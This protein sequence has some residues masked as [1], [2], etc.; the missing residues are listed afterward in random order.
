MRALSLATALVVFLGGCSSAF[1]GYSIRQ[2]RGAETRRI[3]E[4][5]DPL[6]VALDLPSLK[7]IT[8]ASPCRIGFAVVR[9]P[10]VNVWSSPASEA[11]CLYF[12]LLVT[13]GAL[14]APT[15]ELMAM[16]AHELGHLT[17]RHT[18]QSTKQ[19]ALSED[20]WRTIQRQELEADRFAVA[21]LKR[22]TA[23]SSVASCEAMGRFLRRGVVDWY[24]AAISARLETAVTE[25]VESAEAACA[26]TEV[27]LAPPEAMEGPF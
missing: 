7:S 6:L 16:L 12:S 27:T 11:P 14:A 4:V 22:M 8:A 13:E 1:Q 5:L 15:D 3:G 19:S 17:L 21:L 24:G 26:S 2:S 25:R 23:S 18:P 9:T 10:K 20:A